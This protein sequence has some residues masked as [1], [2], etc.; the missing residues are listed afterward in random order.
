M[1]CRHYFSRFLLFGCNSIILRIYKMEEVIA[2]RL[3]ENS[4]KSYMSGI[5]NKCHNTRVS[6][7]LYALNMGVLIC[8]VVV[9]GLVLYYCYKTRLSPQEEYQKKLK[10]Q[11]YI[12]SKIKVYKE[13]Q[14][15]IS[16]R[17]SITGLPTLDERPLY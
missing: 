3:I 2:P 8:F 6:I 11:E 10:E 9:V 7:Y 15:N 14:R 1:G 5:L 17:A 12:L 16:S 13:H 4:A